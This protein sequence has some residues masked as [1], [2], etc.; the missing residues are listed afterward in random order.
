M[1]HIVI[2]AFS[3]NSEEYCT[4]YAEMGKKTQTFN[5]PQK[6]VI[7][8]VFSEDGKYLKSQDLY[9]QTFE[10]VVEEDLWV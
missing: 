7:N 2:T 3:Q 5:I 10:W 9:G 4:I 6:Y 1:V 8:A